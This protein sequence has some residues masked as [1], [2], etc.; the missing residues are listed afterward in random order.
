MPAFGVQHIGC[1][2]V[3][4]AIAGLE[5]WIE[6]DE[7]FRPEYAGLKLLANEIAESRFANSNEAAGVG[8]V[9]INQL[10]TEVENVHRAV[11]ILGCPSA[12]A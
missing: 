9:V 6:L 12:S 3:V 4:D 11:L 1:Y 2:K 8:G 7:W 10:A 5:G